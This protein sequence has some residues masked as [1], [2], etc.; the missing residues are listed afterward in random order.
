M[1]KY[2]EKIK[3]IKSEIEAATSYDAVEQPLEMLKM[4]VSKA[5]S[6]ERREKYVN[7]IEGESFFPP[8]L[9]SD[10]TQNVR[11]MAAFFNIGKNSLLT[12][13]NVILADMEDDDE[14]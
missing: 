6:D 12:D 13:I 9:T 7:L 2:Y 4:F 14:K 10:D 5:F 8:M 11:A 1:N 3:K